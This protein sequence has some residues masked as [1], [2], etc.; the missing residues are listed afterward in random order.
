MPIYE[1]QEPANSGGGDFQPIAEDTIVE[2]E[3][4]NVRVKEMPWKDDSGN[5]VERTEFEFVITEDGYDGR[6]LWGTTGIKL[7]NHPDCK[8]KAWSQE[9]FGQEFPPN[10]RLDTDILVGK[11]ARLVV[12]YREYE[13]NGEKRWANSVKDVIRARNPV[14]S[15]N[16]F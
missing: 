8:L 15:S 1:M 16:P 12:G 14:A 11:R 6:R 2:G 4:L 10:Y 9:I 5:A 7:V 13:K 3:L